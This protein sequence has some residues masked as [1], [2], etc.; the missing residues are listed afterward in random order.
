MYCSRW[1]SPAQY[2][3]HFVI[4]CHEP[5]FLCLSV[6]MLRCHIGRNSDHTSI[7]NTLK[8]KIKCR[9]FA[10]VYRWNNAD[11]FRCPVRTTPAI[12]ECI[13]ASLEPFPDTYWNRVII[14]LDNGTVFRCRCRHSSTLAQ[15]DSRKGSNVPY[16][17]GDSDPPDGFC[18]I[19]LTEDH[20]SYRDKAGIWE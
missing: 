14:L 11:P 1:S 9:F 16:G 15:S 13:A 10:P 4:T 6:V 5:F 2:A 8:A 19:Q 18:Q 12:A 17:Q 20:Q 7:F 3:K